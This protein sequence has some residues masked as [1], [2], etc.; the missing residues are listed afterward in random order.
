[1]RIQTITL[2]SAIGTKY[3]KRNKGNTNLQTSPLSTQNAAQYAY[4][5]FNISFAARL[6]RTPEDFHKQDFNSENM[7]SRVKE[8]LLEDFDKRKLIHP[9]KLQKAAYEW[10]E[11][12]NEVDDI[13]A[14]Y[15]QEPLF[16]DLKS[17]K[18]T[19][20]TRGLL[21]K[22]RILE[23]NTK[24]PVFKKE[25]KD[26]N[27]DDLTVYLVKKIYLEGKT[28][29]EINKDFTNES[30]EY[31]SE[32]LEGEKFT[33]ADLKSLGVH[34]PKTAYW[35]SF[36][37]TRADKD[38]N[39][40]K[41]NENYYKEFEKEAA[42]H[43][44]QGHEVSQETIKKLSE[45]STK[46]WA[47]LGKEERAE[48]I[49]KM[50]EGRETSKS[51]YAKY[52]GPLRTLAGDRIGYSERLSQ[53]F[54]ERFSDEEFLN[55]FP[56]FSQRCSEIMLEFWNKDPKFRENYTRACDEVT[57]EFE[58]AILRP[59]K[60]ELLENLLNKAL[61][62]KQKIITNANKR[63]QEKREYQRKM[64]RQ[65]RELQKHNQINTTPKVNIN[66]PSFDINSPKDVKKQFKDEEKK[67]IKIFPEQFQKEFLAFLSDPSNVD[68]KLMQ[69]FVAVNIEGGYEMLNMTTEEEQDKL[70]KEVCKKVEELNEKF[71][72]TH[73]ST[74]KTSDFILS[75]YL[76]ETSQDPN[77][78]TKARGELTEEIFEHN[79]TQ[80]IIDN[81]NQFN[82]EMKLLAKPLAEKTSTQFLKDIFVPNLKYKLTKGFAFY[83]DADTDSMGIL[84]NEIQK[85]HAA[86]PK[87]I[88]STI[89]FLSNYNA[90][91]K[92]INSRQNDESAKEAV[93]E[94]I[95]IDY[96]NK[97][98]EQHDSPILK[99]YFES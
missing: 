16:K 28:L 98:L 64:E 83:P 45:S 86:N 49:R 15:P 8:Y 10:L 12:S 68:F 52:Q 38:Y 61:D 4:R 76:Y 67:V 33:Y 54:S 1:M 53:V 95:I 79:R 82:K 94:H 77:I 29:K 34:F 57:T 20:A 32:L 56:T 22:L 99:A 27:N 87:E 23:L 14:A 7:P 72:N 73:T 31:V 58:D 50:V 42:K 18:N 81:A 78:F 26:L 36:Q 93:I 62:V 88:Q 51:P 66:V 65:A 37:A 55:D 92:F 47:G 90:Q 9:T 43:S 35:N 21:Y 17:V 24:E 85:A 2:N 25:F 69:K 48:Q 97:F 5:D 63:K 19:K 74:A 89:K 39:P 41:R 44:H 80:E 75:N 96:L 30:R 60:P 3:S 59:D 11:A 6:N 13:K 70:Y 91:Y 71:N 84:L 40:S 46:W